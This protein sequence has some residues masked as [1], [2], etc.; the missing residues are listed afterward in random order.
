[1]ILLQRIALETIE[2]RFIPHSPPWDI[3]PEFLWVNVKGKASNCPL[4]VKITI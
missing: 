4:K 3:P 2:A 1:M